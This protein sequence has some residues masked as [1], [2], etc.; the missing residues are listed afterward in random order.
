MKRRHVITALGT[1]ATGSGIAMGTG[2]FT[3]TSAERS[4]SVS[5]ADDDNALLSIDVGTGEEASNIVDNSS[6]TNNT[7]SI[8]IDDVNRNAYTAF[9]G[10]LTITNLG[11]D[12]TNSLTINDL[13]FTPR[14]GD[15]TTIDPSPL[16][17]YQTAGTDPLHEDGFSLNSLNNSLDVTLG[18]GDSVQVGFVIDTTTT[19]DADDIANVIVAAETSESGSENS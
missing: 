18:T 3:T 15:G 12:S 19:S 10:L 16:K 5:T 4:F 17:V 6:N 7:V 11:G 2:A 13:T 14:K 9:D 1:V 8:T